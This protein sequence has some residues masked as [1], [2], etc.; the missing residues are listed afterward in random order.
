CAGHAIDSATRF[1]IASTS[2]AM[3]TGVLARLVDAGKLH[4]NDPVTRY[5]PSFRMY[6]P[7][8]TREIQARDLLIHDIG[9]REGA[10]DLMTWPEPN[11]FT[12]SDI[13]SGL[14]WLKPQHSFRSR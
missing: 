5:L 11:L 8:V 1:K 2:K 12:R 7:W 10:G 14:A 13:L 3:T 4:W 9:L 6:D